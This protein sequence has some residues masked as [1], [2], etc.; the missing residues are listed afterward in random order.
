[1][2]YSSFKKHSQ[3]CKC[4][5]YQGIII[6]RYIHL[7]VMNIC[8]DCNYKHNWK[9][10]NYKEMKTLLDHNKAV[11]KISEWYMKNRRIRS[12]NK[13]S[14]W[15]LQCKY[16]PSYKYCR[17]RLNELYDEEFDEEEDEII[18][19]KLHPKDI[20]KKWYQNI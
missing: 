13:I 12:V 1:M 9:G 10:N 5:K 3:C 14:E 7:E 4:K 15:F 18:R 19:E 11:S 20:Y 2:K 6:K 16:N 17:S 8:E